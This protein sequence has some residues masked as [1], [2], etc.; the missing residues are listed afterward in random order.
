MDGEDTKHPAAGVGGANSFLEE[1]EELALGE[2]I[3]QQA[4]DRVDGDEQQVVELTPL[5]DGKQ[6][7]QLLP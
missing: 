6:D 7:H 5:K 2:N 1:D 4:T 3:I